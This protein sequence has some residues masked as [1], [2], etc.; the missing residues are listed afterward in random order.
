MGQRTI[1]DPSFFDTTTS[2][3]KL[4]AGAYRDRYRSSSRIS[5][6]M[7]ARTEALPVLAVASA[8]LE[9]LVSA[10]EVA[11]DTLSRR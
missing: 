5:A 6:H 7:Q 4:L 1:R 11:A 10:L 8:Q 3:V 2:C 9:A